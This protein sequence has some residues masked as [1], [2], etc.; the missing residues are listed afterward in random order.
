SLSS[1]FVRGIVTS[2][3]ANSITSNTIRNLATGSQSTGLSVVGIWQT[4]TNGGTISQNVIYSLSNTSNSSVTPAPN[5]SVTV[6]G[7]YYDGGSNGTI[8]RNLVHSLTI[9]A[10]TSNSEV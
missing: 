10:G 6:T 7:I 8:D 4:S 3:G 9:D 1:A 5:A 2:S